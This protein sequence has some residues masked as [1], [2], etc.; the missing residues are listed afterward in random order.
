MRSGRHSYFFLL[1]AGVAGA[2]SCLGFSAKTS[3]QQPA[4][5]PTTATPVANVQPNPAPATTVAAPEFAPGV[6]TT[7]PPAVDR[8]D[9]LSVHDVVEIRADESLKW[10]PSSTTRSRTLYEMAKGAAY[11]ND[12]WCLEFTFKPLRM[13][14]VDVPQ[15]NGR[16]QRKLIWYMVYRVRNTGAGI[17]GEVKPDGEFA[18]AP[19]GVEPVRFIPEFTLA[20]QDRSGGQR[21][22]KAYLDRLVPTA[23]EPIRLRELPRGQLLHSAEAPRQELRIE[24]GRTQQG[25]WGV[26][27]WEDVDPQI[28]FFSVYVRGLSNAYQWTDPQGAYK[29]GDPLGAGRRFTYKTL[30]L[31][32]WRPGD[33]LDQSEREFRF[34][35]APGNAALYD[36]GEGVAYRWVYR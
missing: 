28:D 19:K 7:I 10:E 15:A 9:A 33:E 5:G 26:A 11:V 18:T 36:S 12:V 23:L 20:S 22:R 32:F 16:L 14:E 27:M 35:A 4:A 25:M 17:A 8:E 24:S 34:G 6:L 1:A 21:V 31:N 29:K 2:A 30:Q 13:I 3:A